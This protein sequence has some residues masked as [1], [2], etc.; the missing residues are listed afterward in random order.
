VTIQTQRRRLTMHWFEQLTGLSPDGGNGVL[1]ALYDAIACVVVA[2]AV[3][4][5]VVRRRARS[6]R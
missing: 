1:E 3:Y 4:V 6:R 2:T 5:S